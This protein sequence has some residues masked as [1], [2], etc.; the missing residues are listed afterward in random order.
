MIVNVLIS[1]ILGALMVVAGLVL[2]INPELLTGGTV[3]TDTFEAIERR[4]WWGLIIG[5]GV[6]LLLHHHFQPWLRT[7]VATGSA[8]LF[9]LLAARLIGIVLDGSVMEQWTYAGIEF[10]VLAILFWWYLSFR[11]R[12]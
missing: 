8:L 12:R 4:V 10:A 9:G 11:K 5:V 7:L 6:L 1:R 3:P 2:V